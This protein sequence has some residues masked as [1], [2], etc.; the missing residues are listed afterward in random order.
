[1]ENK[2]EG[3]TW[4]DLLQTV[5]QEWKNGS[6]L[7]KDRL[8]IILLT[9]VLLLVIALPVSKEPETTSK[10]GRT[11]TRLEGSGNG[12]TNYANQL[13]NRLEQALS[14]VEGVGQVTVMV[15][16]KSSSEKVI[17]KDRESTSEDV[18]E[19]DSQGGERSTWKSSS[20]EETIYEAGESSSSGQDQKPYVT[21]ELN[22]EIEGIVVIAE[23]G[24]E[25]VV[26][27]NI[28]EAVQAL[29]SVDTHK[30][31]VMKRNQNRG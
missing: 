9:G 23:G 1:M 8:L 13:E 15:T 11:Q 28:T 24:D 29:F 26:V 25:P 12:E 30:I 16:L 19:E 14:Q 6:L 17:E 21:K 4:K 18:K 22:P 27:E 20:K 31:K 10:K 7:K 5:K 2:K 3:R